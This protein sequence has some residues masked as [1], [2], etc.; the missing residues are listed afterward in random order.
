MRVCLLRSLLL[1]NFL[2]HSWQS[3]FLF[4]FWGDEELPRFLPCLFLHTWQINFFLSVWIERY[5]RR[6][7]GRV[8]T[9]MN[10]CS[11]RLH[12]NL[13]TIKEGS[14]LVPLLDPRFKLS[15]ATF[16]TVHS[17]AHIL[18][19]FAKVQSEKRCWQMHSHQLLRMSG[20]GV[21]QGTVWGPGTWRGDLARALPVRTLFWQPLIWLLL[22]LHHHCIDSWTRLHV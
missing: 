12:L 10:T 18:E 1:V 19:C 9:C 17:A 20:P 21:L 3:Y 5:A 11:Q 7:L 8:N 4:V 13:P 14:S 2:P 15:T 22:R 16:L 6:R